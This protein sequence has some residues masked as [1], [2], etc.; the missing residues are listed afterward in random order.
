MRYLDLAELKKDRPEY[1]KAGVTK[2]MFGAV[3]SETSIDGKWQIV[4]SEFYTG[5][6]IADIPVREK[7]LQIHEFVPADRPPKN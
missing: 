1:G 4:F 5:R 3:M 7:D 6:D 2:G